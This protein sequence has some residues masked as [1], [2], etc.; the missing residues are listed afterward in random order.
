MV[1]VAA[2]ATISGWFWGG[3]FSIHVASV[4][5][6]QKVNSEGFELSI[7]FVYSRLVVSAG[8]GLRE[9]SRRGVGR[10]IMLVLRVAMNPHE[11]AIKALISSL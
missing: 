10:L 6:S 7:A 11:A 4:F 9:V 1:F 3:I 2:E 5:S 8:N